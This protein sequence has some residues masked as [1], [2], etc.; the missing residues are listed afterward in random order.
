MK[1]NDDN[2]I[3]KT[4]G[5]VKDSKGKTTHIY[6]PIKE[7]AK[8]TKQLKEYEQIKKKEKIKWIRVSKPKA[9]K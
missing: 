3:I 7:Y 9:K 1:N 4:S 8:I 2:N 6:L 5:Y